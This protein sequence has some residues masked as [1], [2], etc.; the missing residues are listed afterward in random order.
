VT[1]RVDATAAAERVSNRAVF[2]VRALFAF[3]AL[4]VFFG[5]FVMRQ[6]LLTK[7]QLPIRQTGRPGVGISPDPNMS[8][9]G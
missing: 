8:T 7:H 3:C 2:V 6:A 9:D 4:F 5:E 1:A